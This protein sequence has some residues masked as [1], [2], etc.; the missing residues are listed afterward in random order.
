MDLGIAEKVALVTGGSRGI[1]RAVAEA[2]AAEGA[3]TVITYREDEASAVAVAE[4]LGTKPVQYTMGDPGSADR[5]MA[6]VEQEWGGADILVT[7]ALARAPRRPSGQHFEDVAPQQWA[8]SIATNLNDTIRL[9][10]LAVAG[11]RRRGWGRIAFVSSHV[12]H[13]GQAGQEFYAAGK[14]ALHGLARS[15]AWDAGPD[16]VLVNVVCPGLTTTEGV[17]THLPEEVRRREL[18][19]TATGRLSTPQDVAGA[20][21]FLCSAVNRAITG[22]PHTVAGGR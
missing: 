17:L 16:G 4:T 20:V 14:A 11:M 10:Q 18:Q 7:N 22:A 2:F 8:A 19:R 13:D 5:L 6:T 15:L 9:A 3:H 1:G 21:V 12:V